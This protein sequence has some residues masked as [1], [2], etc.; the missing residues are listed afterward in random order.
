MATQSY[1][2]V[3]DTLDM[4]LKSLPL[5][6]GKSPKRKDSDLR[7][8]RDDVEIVRINRDRYGSSP[9]EVSIE[10]SKEQG[11]SRVKRKKEKAY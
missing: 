2:G 9:S 10:E 6:P 3:I 1:F 8:T 11:M 5:K 7:T 4:C